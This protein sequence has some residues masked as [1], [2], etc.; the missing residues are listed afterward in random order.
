MEA[1][2]ERSITSDQADSLESCPTLTEDHTQ[3]KFLVKESLVRSPPR[4]TKS[5]KTGGQF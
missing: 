2:G 3:R 5:G 4:I 1:V